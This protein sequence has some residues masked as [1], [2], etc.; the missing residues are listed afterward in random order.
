MLRFEG[1]SWVPWIM[2]LT[3]ED[4]LTGIPGKNHILMEKA[5]PRFTEFLCSFI[6]GTG[7]HEKGKSGKLLTINLDAVG[8][9]LQ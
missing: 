7:T 9:T 3:Y 2:R 8:V 4:L 1:W 6:I 5:D